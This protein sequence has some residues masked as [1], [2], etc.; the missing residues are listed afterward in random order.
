MDPQGTRPSLFTDAPGNSP[1]KYKC[2]D[3]NHIKNIKYAANI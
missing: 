3:R 1:A 2:F